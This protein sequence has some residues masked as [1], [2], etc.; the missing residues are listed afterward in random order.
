MPSKKTNQKSVSTSLAPTT[1]PA[2]PAASPT[3]GG[4][5]STAEQAPAPQA[6]Q[7]PTPSVTTVTTGKAKMAKSDAQTS[8]VSLIGGLQAIYQSAEILQLP[9]GDKTRDEVVADLQAFVQTAQDTKTAYA[10]WRSAVEKERAV[11]AQTQP[12]KSAI[13]GV[14][15][16]RFGRTSSTLLQFGVQPAKEQQRTAA[17]K[18]AAAV[19]GAATRKARGTLGSK[20]KLAVSGNVTGVTITPITSGPSV[21]VA[22]S[23]EAAPAPAPAAATPPAPTPTTTPAAKS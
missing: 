3:S 1:T 4:G 14:I 8:Y 10:A 5:N 15:R 11:Y 17:S 18:T 13:V 9:M 20:Q 6:T 21:P 22:S 12:E 19:K 7:A 23:N 16:A 2:S